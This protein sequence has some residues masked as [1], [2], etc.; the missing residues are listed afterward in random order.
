MSLGRALVMAT[1]CAA[2][3]AS[4]SSGDPPFSA[5]DVCQGA[6]AASF[7]SL[8]IVHLDSA[9]AFDDFEIAPLVLGGQGGQMILYRIAMEGD[10]IPECV[11]FEINFEECLDP[12]CNQVNPD[13]GYPSSQRLA[14]YMESSGILTKPHFQQ[15][16]FSYGPGSLMRLQVAAGGAE[17]SVLLWLDSIGSIVDAGGPRA[18]DSGVIDGGSGL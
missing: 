9:T 13:T 3:F 16:I 4:T 17:D 10:N 2:A 12:L 5:A 18:P 14:T 8:K 6:E 7:L 11:E 1:A 15:L